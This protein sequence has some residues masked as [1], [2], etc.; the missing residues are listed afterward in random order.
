MIL[1][2]PNFWQN[3]NFI[4]FLLYPLSIVTVIINFYKKLNIKNY[5]KIKTICVG[6]LNAGGT[7][8]TSLAIEL[9]KLLSIKYKTVFIK[10]KYS[11]QKDEFNL[12]KSRGKIINVR[13]RINALKIAE[14]N[15]DLAILDDGFN[16][17]M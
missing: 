7:G 4:S 8:K 16:K 14:R 11:N 2:K 17:K 6:N 10:K 9:Y 3:R 1:K 12:L 5:F 13:N 15:F